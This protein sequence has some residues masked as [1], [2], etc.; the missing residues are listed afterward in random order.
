MILI[1]IH[2][3]FIRRGSN[4]WSYFQSLRRDV[5]HLRNNFSDDDDN[6]EDDV[7]E[8]EHDDI[9]DGDSGE[10]PKSDTLR[11]VVVF[12]LLLLHF[13]KVKDPFSNVNQCTICVKQKN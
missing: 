9:D 2:S 8:H 10:R 11:F 5:L 4:F 12:N 13:H 6:N 1:K 7:D 3:Y